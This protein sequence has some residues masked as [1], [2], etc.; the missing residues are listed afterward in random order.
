M[1]ADELSERL[2]AYIALLQRAPYGPNLQIPETDG[3][4]LLERAERRGYR[5]IALE[6]AAADPAYGSQRDEYYGAAG[7][8]WL[9][10]WAL[11][12]GHRGEFFAGEP[13]APVGP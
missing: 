12:E 4:L 13:E 1:P 3:G 10:R 2:S 5:F 8:S 9:H 7:I 6:E 11:T